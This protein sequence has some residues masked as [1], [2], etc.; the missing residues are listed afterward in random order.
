[1]S[2]LRGAEAGRFTDHLG[3]TRP[4]RQ[5]SFGKRRKFLRNLFQ[6]QVPDPPPW[7]NTA[8]SACY[9]L[10]CV[11]SFPGNLYD[12]CFYGGRSRCGNGNG[13]LWIYLL[14]P[15]LA[16][17]RLDPEHTYEPLRHDLNC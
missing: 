8:Q 7:P 15:G 13:V 5:P 17:K 3:E 9:R 10:I 2:I 11:G 1:M 12:A 16:I 4:H 14:G 6:N